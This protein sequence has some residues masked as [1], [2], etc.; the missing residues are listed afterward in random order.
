[1]TPQALSYFHK[2]DS[3]SDTDVAENG[4]QEEDA[5]EDG[6]EVEGESDVRVPEA[7]EESR[8]PRVGRRLML[9]PGLR[10]TST[11]RYTSIIYRGVRTAYSA[12]PLKQLLPLLKHLAWFLQRFLHHLLAS[13]EPPILAKYP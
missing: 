1:M 13:F 8:K 4:A 6:Q 9:R 3:S 10:A 5:P 12:M 2:S 11:F 7:H